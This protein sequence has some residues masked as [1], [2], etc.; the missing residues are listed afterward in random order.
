[1]FYEGCTIDEIRAFRELEGE[2]FDFGEGLMD[3]KNAESEDAY[4]EMCLPEE[5]RYDE[6][7][8]EYNYRKNRI[9]KSNVEL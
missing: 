2:A 9:C 7:N 5:S 8:Y 3:M 1:M 4:Y 6:Y